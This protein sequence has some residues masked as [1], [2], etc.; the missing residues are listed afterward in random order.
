MANF[1]GGGSIKDLRFKI[2]IFYIQLRF[3][4]FKCSIPLPYSLSKEGNLH[5]ERI[6]RFKE[7]SMG[8]NVQFLS[9]STCSMQRLTPSAK[10]ETYIWEGSKGSRMSLLNKLNRLVDF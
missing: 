1:G 9:I 5:L 8:S 7:R 2:Y 10:R 3:N 4:A 6:K